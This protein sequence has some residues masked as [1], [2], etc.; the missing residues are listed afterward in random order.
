MSGQI[1]GTDGLLTR[2]PDSL[3]GGVD[4]RDM[5]L[6]KP[7]PPLEPTVSVEREETLDLGQ[8][9]AGADAGRDTE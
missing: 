8:A 4:L 2:R 9:L 3:H 1:A 6:P 7:V 5:G